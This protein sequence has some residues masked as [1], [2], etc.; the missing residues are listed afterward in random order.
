MGH[1]YDVVHVLARP[2]G[3]PAARVK[4]QDARGMSYLVLKSW[5]SAIVSENHVNVGPMSVWD[6]KELVQ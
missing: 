4:C 2:P 1:E 5:L 6:V 3:T